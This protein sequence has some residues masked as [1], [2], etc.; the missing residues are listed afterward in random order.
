LY[1]GAIKAAVNVYLPPQPNKKKKSYRGSQAPK[2][3]KSAI[4][5]LLRRGRTRRGEEERGKCKVK[6]ETAK[7]KKK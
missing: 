7:Q 1:R 5:S 6:W 3:G 2:Q 4:L